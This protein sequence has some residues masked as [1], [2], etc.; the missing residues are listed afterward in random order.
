[1][2]VEFI[3]FVLSLL[4]GLPLIT[5]HIIT[6]GDLDILQFSIKSEHYL[7]FFLSS[8]LQQEE[9]KYDMDTYILS[10]VKSSVKLLR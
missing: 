6:D 4:S 1:M 2:I 8:T 9:S 5:S 7:E 3:Y 10:I